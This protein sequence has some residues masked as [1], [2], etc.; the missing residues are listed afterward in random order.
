MIKSFAWA[1][2]LGV[3]A[4]TLLLTGCIGQ[5]LQV[6]S[7]TAAKGSEFS[8]YMYDEYLRLSTDEYKEA[9]YEDSD[10]FAMRA[11][12][13]AG[14]KPP[15]PEMVKARM[16]PSHMV[17]ELAG[18]R[19]VL[20]ELLDAGGR[21]KAPVQAALAQAGFD[22]WLQEQEENI[23]PKHIEECKYQ[24]TTYVKALKRALAPKKMKKKAKK[25]AFKQV[26]VTDA[27]P[28]R[29]R[30]FANFTVYFAFNSDVIDEKSL[31][32]LDKAARA[33]A[34][35]NAKTVTVSGYTD[36]AGSAAYNDGLAKRRGDNVAAALE[37]A[38]I[39]SLG[40]KIKKKVFG[41]KSNKVLTANGK[42]EPKNR[43]VKIE[44]FR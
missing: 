29:K 2:V 20:A 23:Q 19:R 30:T 33:I 44:I 14:G 39:V 38:S 34:E 27:K 37:D 10:A 25:A 18:A 8:Q 26:A 42:R 32:V 5:Q 1:K 4:A 35:I 36:R 21:D 3:A 28:M 12:A 31:N 43:R 13:S 9:D 16:I 24:Y 40:K 41:E 7:G 15:A 22:C 6:A 17:G 11:I